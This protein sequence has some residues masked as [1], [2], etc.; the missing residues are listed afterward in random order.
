MFDATAYRPDR[1]VIEGS[2]WMRNTLGLKPFQFSSVHFGSHLHMLDCRFD[3]V[4]LAAVVEPHTSGYPKVTKTGRCHIC[5]PP[6]P[7]P[8]SAPVLAIPAVPEVRNLTQ[9]DREFNLDVIATAMRAGTDDEVQRLRDGYCRQLG[10]T[11]TCRLW[12]EAGWRRSKVAVTTD[13]C[14]RVARVLRTFKAVTV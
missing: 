14:A 5:H 7:V 8:T 2:D 9:R 3:M 13:A 10:W 4:T 6:K 12:T 1:L 11:A